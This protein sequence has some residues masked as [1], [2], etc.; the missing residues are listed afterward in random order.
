M[1][2]A[3]ATMK[4]I[5]LTAFV[6][7]V[8]S[9]PHLSEAFVRYEERHPQSTVELKMTGYTNYAPFGYW[10]DKTGKFQTAFQPVLDLFK[11][12]ANV[13]LEFYG[14]HSSLDEVAQRVR[15]GE[16]DFIIGA[17][18]QTN[19]FQGIQLLYPAAF[20]N[21]ISIVTLPQNRQKITSTTDLK[22]LKGVR[23]TCEMMSDFVERDMS[24]LNLIEVDTPY[25]MF[26]K[27]F[28]RQVDYIVSSYYFI[29]IEA[30]KL[31]IQRQIAPSK[32]VVWNIPMFVGVSKTS[33]HREFVAKRLTS[34][35]NN[36]SITDSIED[37][38]QEILLEVEKQ[39]QGTVP[40]TFGLENADLVADDNTLEKGD[41][42]LDE[43]EK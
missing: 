7:L 21:P 1:S 23:C 14:S 27:L 16:I 19:T 29:R 5:L 38:L 17:Y 11:K 4:K 31:G 37:R 13:K 32:Q 34:Y 8:F 35:L 41:N 24:P 3:K 22:N 43:E 26:E 18:Y 20:L 33:G 6:C 39:Y 9:W 42:T 25:E 15:K 12:D 40:E 36:K 30:I 10:D 2:E 28:T